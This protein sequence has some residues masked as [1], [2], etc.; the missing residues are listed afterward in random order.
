MFVN[1]ILPIQLCIGWF[2]LLGVFSSKRLLLRRSPNSS[3]EGAYDFLLNGPSPKTP[4]TIQPHILFSKNVKNH[5]WILHQPYLRW[6]SH[7]GYAIRHHFWDRHN[8]YC[9]FGQALKV[10]WATLSSKSPAVAQ[11]WATTCA[12]C[13]HMVVGAL[14]G[15]K[16]QPPCFLTILSVH[17]PLRRFNTHL[18]NYYIH[19]YL[20][21]FPVQYPKCLTVSL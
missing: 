4:N 15:A 3:N 8:L 16:P 21:R 14:Y 1:P 12:F 2:I 13:P 19:V 11:I 17:P 7:L 9:T 10:C 6:L 20:W 5:E 18:L